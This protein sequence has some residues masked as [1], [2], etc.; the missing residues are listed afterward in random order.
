MEGMEDAVGL[1]HGQGRAVKAIFLIL[2][3][4]FLVVSSC[5]N[6]EPQE[7]EKEATEE[8]YPRKEVQVKY[9]KG[10]EI[11]YSNQSTKIISHSFGLNEPFRDSIYL[12]HQPNQEVKSYLSPNC[13]AIA[14]QST[15]HLA[16]LDVL[17]RLS[18]VKALC[19]LEYVTN[20]EVVSQLEEAAAVEICMSESIQLEALLNA[21][22]DLFLTY[23][24]GSSEQIDYDQKGVKTFMIA[25]YLE[26][27]QLA[28]LEWIKVFGLLFNC[29]DEANAYFE[30]VEKEYNALKTKPDP[31]KQFIMNLPWGE[32][33][34]MPSSQSVGVQLMEDAGL[35]YYFRN[36]EGTENILRSKEQVWE[37]GAEA[38]YWIIIASRPPG[39]TLDDLIDEDPVYSE[40]KSV[41]YQQVFFCNTATA[42]YFAKGVVEPHV[43]LKDLLFLT[44]QIGEH[45]PV[46]FQRLD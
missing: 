8:T 37:A 1:Y 30:K 41:K 26:Q 14:S 25:E 24:F 32:Q 13:D 40:F 3:V 5:I 31:K 21:E 46:Y 20:P 35:Q 23:P 36:E 2:G 45:E 29:S 12:L 43:L 19:G 6:H 7:Q 10:F 16:F 34:F 15:T 4:L 39:F 9:A 28:R 22:V 33:W 11:E 18:L 27:D 38:N 42:D 44:H 17:N